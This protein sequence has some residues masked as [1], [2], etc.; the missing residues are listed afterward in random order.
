MFSGI[1]EEIGKITEIREDQGNIDFTINAALASEV[2]VDQS[3]SHDGVCLTVI[4]CDADSYKV[5]AVKETL[6]L[7]SLSSKK[8]G[9]RFNLERCVKVGDRLDG[10]IVQG[11][12]D[13]TAQCVRVQETDGSWRFTFRYPPEHKHLVVAKGSITIN[14]VSLTVIDPKTDVFSV[15]I[16]PYTF[17]HTTF[18]YLSEGDLVNLEFDIIGKY[19]DRRL[20]VRG[21]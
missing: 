13:C 21:L 4:A 3:I 8:V 5:T 18:R 20:K 19:L 1:I 6:S 17:S 9:S 7:T 11:H 2:K 14:G 15:A 10:H 16:I 12:V